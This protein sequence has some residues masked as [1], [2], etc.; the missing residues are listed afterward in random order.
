[1]QIEGAIKT[2]GRGPSVIE[3]EI[4]RGREGIPGAGPPDVSVLNYFLYKQ[5]IAR[6][7]AIG[8]RILPFRTPGSPVNQEAIDHY[9]DLINTVLEYGMKPLVTLHHFDTPLYYIT[10]SASWQG[11]DHPEFVDGFLNYAKIVLTHYSDRVG[12]WITFNEPNVDA[13]T[14]KNWLSSYNVVMAHAK[15]VHFYREQIKGSGKW[16]L[17]LAMP[18]GGERQLDFTLGYM[19][20]PIYLGTQVPST[21][22][23]SLGSRAPSYTEEELQYAKG[24]ADFFAIDF[25]TAV[26]ATTP[27][28]GIDSCLR[29]S[30]NVNFPICTNITTVRSNWQIR[31]QSNTPLWTWYQHARVM[32]RYL[33]TTYPTADGITIAE[34]GWPGFHEYDMTED[35]ARAEFASTLFYLPILNEMLKSIHEDGVKFKGALGWAFVDNW[36][37]GECG[38]RYGVQA[39]N[40]ETLERSYKRSIF[41]IVDFIRAHSDY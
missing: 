24:T 9:D 6:L 38:D 2:E 40:N 28:D 15:I 22:I 7:A 11:Y 33:Y 12:T 41:D 21:V 32:F 8:S 37:W 18:N 31:A 25:Y 1:M 36:E 34:F 27:D 17:K 29:N 4:G 14:T 5:D 10:G 20:N 30:T 23:E 3:A 19:A 13:A 35:R 26:Y 16:S 39:F